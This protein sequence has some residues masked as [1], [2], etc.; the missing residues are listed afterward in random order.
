MSLRAVSVRDGPLRYS[1]FVS[2]HRWIYRIMALAQLALLRL[3]VPIS[4]R[5]I[6]FICRGPLRGRM[7]SG[8]VRFADPRAIIPLPAAPCR[9]AEQ[10]FLAAAR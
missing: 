7:L 6:G 2:R 10:P 1:A 5:L 3:P 9:S 8:Y 4:S